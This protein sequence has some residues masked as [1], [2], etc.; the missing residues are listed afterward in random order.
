MGGGMLCNQWIAR[1]SLGLMGF[2]VV[3]CGGDGEATDRPEFS[4]NVNEVRYDLQ[5]IEIHAVVEYKNGEKGRFTSLLESPSDLDQERVARITQDGQYFLE[6]NGE[7]ADLTLAASSEFNSKKERK[8]QDGCKLEGVTRS[9]GFARYNALQLQW[10]LTGVL[11]GTSCPSGIETEYRDF[12][13]S[14][15]EGLHF[16]AIQKL[17]D[18][19]ILQ[20]ENSRR[21]D[22]EV[23]VVG[24]AR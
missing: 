13:S 12:V 7:F 21:I 9:S 2:L 20:V 14:E 19:G 22:L 4:Q 23:K 15:M 16:S 11:Q 10:K 8:G 5:R 18:S 6:V 3:A 1:V 17:R 24:V